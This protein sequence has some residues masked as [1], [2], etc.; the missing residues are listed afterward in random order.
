MI[1]LHDVIEI[2]HLADGDCGAVFLVVALDR[3]FVGVTAIDR[4]L[5]GDPVTTDGLRQKPPRGLL[6]AVF[7]EQKVDRLALLVNRTIQIAPLAL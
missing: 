5:L 3:G 2:L 6:I 7:G 4:D 1:L